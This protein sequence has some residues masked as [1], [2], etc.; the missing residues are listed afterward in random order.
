MCYPEVKCLF[1]GQ[2]LLQ[3]CFQ[4]F[5]TLV[6]SWLSGYEVG[7]LLVTPRLLGFFLYIF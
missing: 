5:R 3:T 6:K 2:Q 4:P 7:L 1:E